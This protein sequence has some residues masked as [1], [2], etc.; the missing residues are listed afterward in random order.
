MDDR[1]A[2]PTRHSL[3]SRL[4][5]P[6]NEESW[7]VFF[8]TYWRLIYG[9]AIRAGLSD[10]EAQDVVQETVL[11][12]FKKMPGFDYDPKIGT[13]RGWL[14][15]LTRWRILDQLKKRRSKETSLSSVERLA[16]VDQLSAESD[17]L[18]RFWNA[19]WE[20]NALDAAM[21][22]VKKKVDPKHFQIFDLHVRKQVGVG[23]VAKR[24]SVSAAQVYVVKHRVGSLL[25]K[26]LQHVLENQIA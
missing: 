1:N 17:A 5:D 19:E 8:D 7:R 6:A 9:T 24:L 13:F 10:A 26:E 22:R 23:E 3:L 15:R 16:E 12:V 21:E 25:K 2:I 14:L 4:K 18:E 20:R 11:G